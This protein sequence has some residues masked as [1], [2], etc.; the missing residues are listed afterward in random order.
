[1]KHKN[2]TPYK[3]GD[4]RPGTGDAGPGA[5]IS[6][7]LFN[8]KIRRHNANVFS[9]VAGY[10]KGKYIASSCLL[11]SVSL[12]LCFYAI[13]LPGFILPGSAFAQEAKPE[14]SEQ[15]ISMSFREAELDYVLDFFSRATGYTIVKDADIKARVTINSQRDIPVD[16]ALSVLNSILTIKGYTSIIDRKIIKVVPLDTARQENTDIRVGSDPAEMESTDIIV[17]QIMPLSYASATQIVKD[18]KELV[19]KYGIMVAHNRSNTLVITAS[20]SNIKRFAQIVKELDI[21]MSD[22]IKVEVFFIKYRDAENLAKIIEEMFEKPRGTEAEEQERAERGRRARGGFSPFGRGGDAP[23]GGAAETPTSG[24]SERLQVMGDVKVV[25]DTDTNALV[26]SASQENLVVIKDLI[27]KLD[28]EITDQAETRIFE[29][30]HADAVELSDK[31]NQAFQS[32]SSRTSGRTQFGFGR[33]GGGFSTPFSPEGQRTQVT[34]EGGILGLPG[35]HL[36]LSHGRPIV[37]P[38][39]AR[40]G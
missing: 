32:S 37:A 24:E 20:S 8:T 10:K 26:V 12:L 25:A 9:R 40:T 36:R 38:C 11:V 30:E 22:L 5:E 4:L 18:L 14:G 16:E 39:L 2:L 3:T 35:Q 1:M 7:P 31:L 29:L 15:L 34:S 19:P 21:P 17:T 13:F 6:G 33:R 23:G 28:R 27:E